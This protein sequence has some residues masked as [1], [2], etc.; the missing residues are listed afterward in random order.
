[1][2]PKS[3]QKTR[4]VLPPLPVVSTKKIRLLNSD[5]GYHNEKSNPKTFIDF[6]HVSERAVV[7]SCSP[8]PPHQNTNRYHVC[9]KTPQ[10]LHM[11]SPPPLPHA[12]MRQRDEFDFYL[13]T[14]PLLLLC[15]SQKTRNQHPLRKALISHNFI[16]RNRHLYAACF[17]P[18][19][20]T[21]AMIWTRKKSQSTPDMSTP[22][23]LPKYS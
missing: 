23:V 2:C 11:F 6:L 10:L 17:I 7:S 22:A 15:R 16:Q 4:H 21:V 5:L 14:P 8:S 18:L 9:R 12:D 20:L 1:V 13:M 19:Y 3:E